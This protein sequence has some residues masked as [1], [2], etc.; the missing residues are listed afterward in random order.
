MSGMWL[1]H[2]LCIQ[3]AVSTTGEVL[4]LRVTI[5]KTRVGAVEKTDRNRLV[6]LS[7]S[8]VV[9]LAGCRKTGEVVFKTPE[10]EV[11]TKVEGGR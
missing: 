7:L 3:S 1:H 2:A 11:S 9:C 5:S 6:V 8:L 10:V 4:F